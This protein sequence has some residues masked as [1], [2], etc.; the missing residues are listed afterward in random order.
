[1]V[2]P[3][4]CTLFELYDEHTTHRAARRLDPARIWNLRSNRLRPAG[5]T[6]ADAAGLPIL[7]GL[8]TYSEVLSGKITHAL[9]MTAE[10][11]DTAYIWPAAR[12][13]LECRSFP[14]SYGGEIRLDANFNISHFSKQ[15][16][17]VLRAMNKTTASSW[18]TTGAT[19][20]SRGPQI[21][22]GRTRSLTS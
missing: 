11:T 22:D 18:P 9:R 4:I 3:K 19:G 16:K 17:V 8:V 10:M 2:N 15:A 13:R 14:A 5:W 6:S 1:M 20:T 21:R 7:P 12:R